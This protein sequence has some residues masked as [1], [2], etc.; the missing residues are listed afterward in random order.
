MW[1]NRMRMQEE[2]GAFILLKPKVGQPATRAS[3][4]NNLFA[5]GMLSCKGLKFRGEQGQ[6]GQKG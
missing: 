3:W 1:K 4:S 5:R 6:Q 2:D